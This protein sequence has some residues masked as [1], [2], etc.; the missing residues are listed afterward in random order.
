MPQSPIS[1]DERSAMRASFRKLLDRHCRP[2]DIRR[3]IDTGQRF[4]PDLWQAI[5]DLGLPGLLVPA[6]RGGIGGGAVDLEALMED[7]GAELLPGPFLSV[8]VLSAALLSAQM[9]GFEEEL[10][11]LASGKLIIATALTGDRGS[12]TPEGVTVTAVETEEGWLLS[13]SASFILDLEAADLLLVAANTGEDNALFAVTMPDASVKADRLTT[14]DLTLDL[15]RAVLDQTSARRVPGVGASEISAALDLARIAI[16]GAQAGLAR[17]M[18]DETVSYLRTRVQFGRP[19][20]AFQALQHMAADMLVAVENATSAARAAAEAHDAN[21]PDRKALV[22]LASF[23]SAD[24][25]ELVTS[26]AIQMHGG[27]AFTWDHPAHLYWRRASAQ[28]QLFGSPDWHREHYLR[29][30]EAVS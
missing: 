17:H 7:A 13:G 29:A 6:E 16:A 5:A 23:A 8:T 12:W 25:A 22:H 24:C 10:A 9:E 4:D 14:A 26:Q 19:I 15:G 28:A 18:L 20:G 11:D 2:A 1:R 21:A 3:S 27:I 30:L